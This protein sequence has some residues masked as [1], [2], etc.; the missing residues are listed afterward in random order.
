[1]S[2]CHL[3][4]VFYFLYYSGYVLNLGLGPVPVPAAALV[5][6][7]DPRVAPAPLPALVALARPVRHGPPAPRAPQ[8]PPARAVVAM[9]TAGGP[10]QSK[11]FIHFL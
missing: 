3:I 2:D 5:P 7:Q 1:M 6:V 11:R 8:R 10:V 9:T 4:R